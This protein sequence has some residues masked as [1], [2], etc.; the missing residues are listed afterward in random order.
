MM[1]TD[2]P[3]RNKN[4]DCLRATNSNHSLLLTATLPGSHNVAANY[5]TRCHLPSYRFAILSTSE[6]LRFLHGRIT[7]V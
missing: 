5:F 7:L 1:P 6:I 3:F 2:T 4:K